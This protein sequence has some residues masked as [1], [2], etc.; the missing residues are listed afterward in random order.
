MEPSRLLYEVKGE[1]HPIVLLP[2]GLTGWLSWIP[3]V[4][5][6]AHEHRVVR[7]QLRSVALAE[8][9]RGIPED[10]STLTERESVRAIVDELGLARFDLVGWSF[11]GHVAL[12]F[13]LEYPDRVRTLTVIE[14]AAEWIL[15]ETG[16][17]AEAVARAEALDRSFADREI[18]ADDLKRFLV[19]VG[20][21]RPGDDFESRAQWPS[22]LAHRQALS[23]GRAVWDYNDSLDR[24]RR[25]DVPILAV[26]STATTEDLETIVDDIAALAPQARLLVLPGD[27]ACHLENPERFLAELAA[28]TAGAHV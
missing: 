28:H 2:G 23:V 26:K 4:D 14:P 7:V 21:G 10:Y 19:R 1:G 12:A 24:L 3:F 25:L 20:F 27:H 6:L 15:R 11:G 17:A 13:A 18:T 9:G 22:W 16:Q 5:P 8:A